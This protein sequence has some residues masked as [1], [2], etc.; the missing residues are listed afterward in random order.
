MTVEKFT[1]KK[2]NRE[3]F[4]RAVSCWPGIGGGCHSSRRGSCDG[5][6]GRN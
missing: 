6:G 5:N 3:A 1:Q 2:E 4:L